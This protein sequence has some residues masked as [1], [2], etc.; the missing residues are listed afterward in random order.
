MTTVQQPTAAA[1]TCENCHQPVS[2]HADAAGWYVGNQRAGNRQC[3]SQLRRKIN[4]ARRAEMTPVVKH[5]A[6]AI[7]GNDIRRTQKQCWS[8]VSK[9]GAWEYHR[10]E[11]PTTPWYI[12]HVATGLIVDIAFGTL[13]Q[14]RRYTGLGHGLKNIEA[15]KRELEAREE[16]ARRDENVWHPAWCLGHEDACQGYHAGLG[17]QVPD[18]DTPG[19]YASVAPLY[20]Q[21]G[22]APGT[23]GVEVMVGNP[24]DGDSAAC[25]SPDDAERLAANLIHTAQ[26]VRDARDAALASA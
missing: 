1:D 21:H 14:A 6:D 23:W 24:G 9:D 13:D 3:A 20:E 16:I 8:A 7:F 22:T 15:Q 12:K 4:A 18:V 11:E 10:E 26:R 17:T 19:H 25:L 5:M 2:E